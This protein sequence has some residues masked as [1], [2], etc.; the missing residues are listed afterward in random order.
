MKILKNNV[1]KNATITAEEEVQ[2]PAVNVYS[3]WMEQIWKPGTG[4]GLIATID[5]G[6]EKSIN[7]VV[8]AFTDAEYS[9]SDSI[10][11]DPDATDSITILSE[12]ENSITISSDIAVNY[13]LKN[14]SGVTVAS[15][16]VCTENEICFDTLSSTVSA[17]YLEVSATGQDT[18]FYIGGI[19]AG[20]YVE[21]EIQANNAVTNLEPISNAGR[22]AEGFVTGRDDFALRQ[23]EMV[24][25]EI[26][27]T[28]KLE[29]Q[30]LIRTYGQATPLY[31]TELILDNR[32][33][34]IH[35]TFQ[36][37]GQFRWDTMNKRYS[38][39]ITILEAR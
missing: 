18:G 31:A 26:D 33:P 23:W 12:A 36:R 14:S 35:G 17:Q 37:I 4:N 22:T 7:S 25:N 30:D 39:G 6:E 3:R 11:I 2:F 28:Q 21:Y 1:V 13:A 15:G 24:L 27:D 20:E 16:F 38:M 34:P 29:L 5:F 32:E 8:F 9:V 19:A 10:T